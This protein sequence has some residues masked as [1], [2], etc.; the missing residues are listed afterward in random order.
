MIEPNYTDGI[1]PVEW[2][3]TGVR[4]VPGTFHVLPV[5]DLVR[6]DDQGDDC[7]CGPHV[8]FFPRGRVVVHHALDGR[9]S[10]DLGWPRRRAGEVAITEAL[11]GL[12][13]EDGPHRP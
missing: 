12:I 7:V 10:G 9:H 1:L 3:D 11:N 8:E 4:R 6:H 5:D 13:E 2:S